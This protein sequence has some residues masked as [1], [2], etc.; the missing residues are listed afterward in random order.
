MVRPR[1]LAVTLGA[2]AIGSVLS[3]GVS[4]AMAG[5]FGILNDLGNAAIG[6]VSAALAWSL[7]TSSAR[8]GAG[9][10]PVA[11]ALV[12]AT[13][14]VVGSYLVVSDT[15][16]FLLA[17]L[18]SATGFALIGLW[19][20]A[21]SRSADARRAWPGRLTSL[22]TVAGIAMLIGVL[23]VPGIAMGIDTVET[24]PGWIWIG[25]VGWIGTY[26]LYPAWAFGFAR[27]TEQ[28]FASRAASA[29]IAS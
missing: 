21:L 5:P 19:L 9:A 16:G 25:S 2:L 27:R 14:T 11:A 22:G 18:V 15:T 6:I 1:V 26:A 28:A 3:L 23:S 24:A 4:F 8:L 17:G 10:L 20:L 13:L 29:T 7:R 12:G